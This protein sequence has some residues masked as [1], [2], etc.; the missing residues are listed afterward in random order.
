M[1]LTNFIV[2]LY[3]II[4]KK[5]Y[6]HHVQQTSQGFITLKLG[7]RIFL[8]TALMYFKILYNFLF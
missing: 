4:K 3:T 5:N 7:S 8:I 2:T 6:E 1:G